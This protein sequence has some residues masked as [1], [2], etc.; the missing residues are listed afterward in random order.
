MRAQISVFIV[1]GLLILVVIG[2]GIALLDIES[3]INLE[4][5]YTL[6]S[7][8]GPVKLYIQTCLEQSAIPLIREIANGGGTLDVQKYRW[9]MG[10]KY[11]YLCL[12]EGGCVHTMLLRQDME[13]ELELAILKNISQCI[14]LSIFERQGFTIDE[15]IKN[16]NVTIGRE[17][18][19]VV[20][21]YP[22]K[23]RKSD[24]LLSID[25]FQTEVR[26]PLGLLYEK[27]LEIINSENTRGYFYQVDY[28]YNNNARV[29]VQKHKP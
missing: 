26:L 14:D 3:D 21:N 5:I 19:G 29:L 11:N 10:D 8:S 20:L 6:K 13:K 28:M 12:D 18:V 9:Y 27:T 7:D 24:L 2:L 23:L 1:A 16:L 17:E 15:G 25:D 4:E 22:L